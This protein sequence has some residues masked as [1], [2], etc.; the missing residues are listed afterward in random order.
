MDFDEPFNRRNTNCW[1]WDAEGRGAELPMGCADTDFR[2][3]P[4]IAAALKAKIDQGALTYPVND[5]GASEAFVAYAHR[6]YDADFNRNHVRYCF[7]MMNG[8]SLLIDAL[9]VPGDE[10]IVQTPVFD[11]FMDTAENA[12]RRIVENPFLHNEE[13]GAY[14]VD[15]EGLAQALERPRV[16][17]MVIC[18]PMNPTGMAFEAH[19][20][21][22]I[23]KM[24][25]EH[26]VILISDEVHADFYWHGKRHHSLHELVPQV[27]D[28]CIIMTGPGKTF[29][30]HGLYTSLFVIPND[31]IRRAY[32][33]QFTRRH[34]DYSEFGM[35]AAQAAYAHGDEYVSQM[36]S[37]IASNLG[38]VERFFSEHDAG[39]RVSPM[40]ATYL[41]WL[42]FR[43]WDM[44]SLEID[45]VLRSRGLILS[46]G[47]GYG[48]GG[49]GFMRMNI[50]TQRR[51]VERALAIVKES[52]E[53]AS[54]R[55]A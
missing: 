49:E 30:I 18:N 29:N 26:G 4:E 11:Y 20:L 43:G 52:Y 55:I 34:L 40:D 33:I 7:G 28:E 54:Q 46:K 23:Y 17:L 8:Y 27:G 42:D 38:V 36:H 13:T 12:G 53:A 24:C 3:M 15:Y 1:K 44:T 21:L 14:S 39:V 32:D 22:R 31:K 2:I 10:I 16:R 50:A 35:I 5:S 47:S 48:V 51:N 41:V 45:G 37:Y 6:H 9:T 25:H 19:D